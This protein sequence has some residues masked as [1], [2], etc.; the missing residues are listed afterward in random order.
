M[1]QRDQGTARPLRVNRILITGAAGGLGGATAALFADRGWQVFAADVRTA[2]PAV[3]IVPIAMDV[4]DAASVDAAAEQIAGQAPDGLAAVVNFA[5]VL[6][7]GP[8]AE[9]TEE[10]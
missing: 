3:R 4:T 1:D 2:A 8:M 5:G 7:I 10:R 6:D 9:I